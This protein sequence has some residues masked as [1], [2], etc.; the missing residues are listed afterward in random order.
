MLE[1]AS[2]ALHEAIG[3][4]QFETEVTACA[5]PNRGVREG[6]K[7]QQRWTKYSQR[8]SGSRSSGFRPVANQAVSVW[9]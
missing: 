4:E 9:E 7:S 6:S 3:V 5:D 8:S 1:V 2:G